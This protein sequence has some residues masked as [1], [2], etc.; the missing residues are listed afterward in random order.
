MAA[1]FTPALFT[2][3]APFA[4]PTRS[5]AGDV[6]HGRF[7]EDYLCHPCLA[8]S[9]ESYRCFSDPWFLRRHC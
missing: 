7:G 2:A 4:S 1:S 3:S 6:H 5:D 8:L 9:G